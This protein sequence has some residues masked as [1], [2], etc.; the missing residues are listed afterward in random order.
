MLQQY[1]YLPI[2]YSVICFFTVQWYLIFGR[3]VFIYAVIRFRSNDPVCNLIIIS[4]FPSIFRNA[5][6]NGL[7][8]R[9][10]FRCG[11]NPWGVQFPRVFPTFTLILELKMDLLTLLRMNRSSQ[12]ILRKVKTGVAQLFLCSGSTH[13][14]NLNKSF[15]VLKNN[16]TVVCCGKL[17]NAMVKC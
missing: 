5:R 16:P 13:K 7:T 12:R 2:N 1:I 4:I 3:M 10:W 17:N 15:P 8:T 14:S 9:S 11:T 6:V